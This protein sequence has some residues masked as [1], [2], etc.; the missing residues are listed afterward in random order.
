MDI[1]PIASL[2]GL[3]VRDALA[4]LGVP[5]H[6]PSTLEETP[7]VTVVPR[8]LSK[9]L[10]PATLDRG[11]LKVTTAALYDTKLY[12]GVLPI[13]EAEKDSQISAMLAT[14][15]DQ[16]DPDSQFWLKPNYEL[17]VQYQR[18]LDEFAREYPPAG[19]IKGPPVIAIGV[20]K[21]AS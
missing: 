19:G 3:T 18:E 7:A 2:R 12:L 4:K 17:F 10:D 8:S 6:K 20:P 9:G 5:S 11:Q 16:A 21:K 1:V 13:S 14:D 15:Y